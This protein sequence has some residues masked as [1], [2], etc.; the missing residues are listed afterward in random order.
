MAA[1][2]LTASCL[3]AKASAPC[4]RTSIS[5]NAASVAAKPFTSSKPASL[6]LSQKERLTATA[7]LP[8]LLAAVHPV[9]A[10]LDLDW[11]DPDTQIGAFGAFLGLAIGIGTPIFYVSRD[12]IDEERLEELRA[13]NRA[14]KAET[15]EYLT[16]EEISAIR[17]PRWTD[18][19]EFV[20]DGE[21]R[22]QDYSCLQEKCD[23]IQFVNANPLLNMQIDLGM[24]IAFSIISS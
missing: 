6:R 4:A 15:G 22:K 5:K 16:E 8:E 17:P 14:T 9:I 10:D 11:S 12:R 13:L 19:R 2:N 7:A 18:R 24:H 21:N 1:L 20:D 3:R 23:F